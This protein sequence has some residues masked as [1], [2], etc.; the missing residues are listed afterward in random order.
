ML[1][2]RR[3]ADLVFDKE[4]RSPVEIPDA[5]VTP[6]WFG[7]STCLNCGSAITTPY[8][9]QCGQ[10]AAERFVL[11]DIGREGWDRVRWFEF[12]LVRTLRRLIT[13]PGRVAREYVMGR[14]TAHM[15][16]LKLLVA[17]V[18]ALC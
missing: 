10:K 9:G 3:A 12:Q 13:G 5:A 14:R 6:E 18:A 8:C 16:P 17:L 1:I 4:Q 7:A 15:H 2:F 11:R